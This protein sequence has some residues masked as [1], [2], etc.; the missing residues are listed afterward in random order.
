MVPD[1]QGRILATLARTSRELNLRTLADL[2]GVSLAHAARVVPRLVE[3]GVVERREVPPAV[4][5]K[6][7]REH[8]A[9]R[10][11]LALADLRHA[12]LDELRETLGRLDRAPVN[13]TLFGSFARGDDD[14]QS[15]VDVIVVRPDSIDEDD[16]SW[17]ESL[18]G[19]EATVRRIS[20][21][22]VNRI[23]VAENE[24]PKLMKSRRPLWQ[25]IGREGI[26]LQGKP[27]VDIGVPT[28]A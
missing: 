12:F 27:L 23:E 1:A 5:V 13:V 7:V 8:L 24:L 11:L 15:D 22:A 20:G 6:L 25:A 17:S 26:V 16:S 21:N 9:A 4:L 18:A 14:A 28:R 10:A 19:W 3:L 2:S